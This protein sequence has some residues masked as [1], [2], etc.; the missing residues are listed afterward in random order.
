MKSAPEI[1]HCVPGAPPRRLHSRIQATLS[2]VAPPPQRR[3][4]K[5]PSRF[6]GADCAI[7]IRSH[8]HCSVCPGACAS[9][10]LAVVISPPKL[11]LSSLHYDAD[12]ASLLPRST[13]PAP[14]FLLPFHCLRR[15]AQRLPPPSVICPNAVLQLPPISYPT[16]LIPRSVPYES[17]RSGGHGK[18]P[19]RQPQTRTIM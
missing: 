18:P 15:V 11:Y 8:T 10:R 7:T 5:A 17:P 16:S 1:R 9:H 6:H 4:Q 2:L 12:D 14:V 19:L 3:C 13:C